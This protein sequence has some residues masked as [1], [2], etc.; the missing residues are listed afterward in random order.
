[1]SAAG[2]PP[3]PPTNG[4]AVRFPMLRTELLTAELLHITTIVMPNFVKLPR[5]IIWGLRVFVLDHTSP[6]ERPSYVET[7]AWTAPV[8]DDGRDDA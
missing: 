1:M 4:A 8:D 6:T 5:V 7:F 2:R 3:L